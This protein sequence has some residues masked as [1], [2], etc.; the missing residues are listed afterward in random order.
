MTETDLIAQYLAK[1]GTITK[2]PPRTFALEAYAPMSFKAQRNAHFAELN[3]KSRQREES[4]KAASDIPAGQVA[5]K[6]PKP[7]KAVAAQVRSER[8]GLIAAPRCQPAHSLDTVTA[9]LKG[10]MTVAE[11]ADHLGSTYAAINSQLRRAG[12]KATAIRPYQARS[13]VARKSPPKRVSDEELREAVKG[14]TANEA[15]EIL[16]MC[17]RYLRKRL[18]AIGLKAKPAKRSVKRKPMGEI[19]AH[20]EAGMSVRQTADAMGLTHTAISDRMARAGIT[21]ASIMRDLHIRTY[22]HARNLGS[23]KARGKNAP[24]ACLIGDHQWTDLKAA[25]DDLG[26]HFNTLKTW[27]GASASTRQRARLDHAVAEWVRRSE[28]VA[29]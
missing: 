14:R 26:V 18:Q 6:Q 9:L 28:R 5:P 17:P 25:A 1:G 27:M 23:L 16:G 13:H 3:A 20:I 10:G 22:G 12:V 29:A 4:Q 11:V 19:I 24:K 2:C 8:Q 21:V 15:A 7:R